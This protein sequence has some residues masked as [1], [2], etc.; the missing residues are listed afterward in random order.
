MQF[1]YHPHTQSTFLLLS[2]AINMYTFF[3]TRLPVRSRQQYYYPPPQHIHTF[4][5]NQHILHIPVVPPRAQIRTM[6]VF[7]FWSCV[8]GASAF[9]ASF[10]LVEFFIFSNFIPFVFFV[11]LCTRATNRVTNFILEAY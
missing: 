6:L 1:F 8:P 5:Y 7:F 4:T 11:L 10:V 9:F 2:F 3:S